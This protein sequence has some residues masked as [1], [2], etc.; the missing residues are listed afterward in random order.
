MPTVIPDAFLSL[1][2]SRGIAGQVGEKWS[3]LLIVALAD[4]PRRFGDLKRTLQ[5]ISQKML[6]QTVRALERDGLVA[7]QVF[8]EMPL[9]VEYRLTALGQ[10]L[11]P[12]A[13]AV[14]GWAE[15]KVDVIAENRR[16]YDARHGKAEVPSAP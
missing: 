13:R 7:R 4:G 12:V 16:T 8:D 3:L 9:R 6:T 14:K 11:L 15:A 5:G 1:C 10:D 2:P